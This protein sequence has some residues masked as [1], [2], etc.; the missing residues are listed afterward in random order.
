MWVSLA[1]LYPL[2]VPVASIYY[3]GKLLVSKKNGEEEGEE[4]AMDFL[5][6]LK[7]FEH[8]GEAGPQLILMIIFIVNN[9]GATEHPVSVTSAVF[10]AGSFLFGMYTSYKGFFDF[11]N[12]IPAEE[13]SQ[14]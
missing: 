3:S 14:V 4:G 1:L 7:L 2:A 13:S 12:I 9:G 10:S 11:C 8:L 5:K 6:V